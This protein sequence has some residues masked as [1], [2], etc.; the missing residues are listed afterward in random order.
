[1]ARLFL[2]VIIPAYN[3]EARI[4]TSIRR[5]AA[6]LE[7][8]AYSWE[9]AVVDDGSTDRTAVTVDSLAAENPK[10]RLLRIPHGGK[11]AAVRYGMLESDAEWRFLCDADL[12]MPPEHIDRFFPGDDGTPLFDVS[13]GSR[14]AP[15]A[16]RFDEPH[17]RYLIGRVFN[18]VV[19]IFAVRGLSDTQC[20]FKLFRGDVARML[21]GQQQLAGF[22]FDVEVL[23]LA[24]KAGFSIGEIAID[25]HHHGGSK[26]SFSKGASAFAEVLKVR[27]NDLLG[28]Y[29]DPPRTSG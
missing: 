11:G 22:G 24:R 12:S 27:L 19:R 20:G 7:G 9:I 13:V 28:R 3:E 15:G 29:S 26:V 2:T 6:H 21:F 4:E 8:K 10:V 23:Y 5:V 16:R 1:M 18:R 25:W 14:E 17:S